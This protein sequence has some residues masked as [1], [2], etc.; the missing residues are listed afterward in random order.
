[1]E[2]VEPPKRIKSLFLSDVHLG[3]IENNAATALDIIEKYHFDNLF[4]VGDIIDIKELRKK[5]RWNSL[6]TN[7]IHRIIKIANKKNVIYITGNHERGF[8]DDLPDSGLPIKFFR[9]LVYNNMLIIHGDQFDVVIG[10]RKWL[11]NVGDIGYNWSIK[12]THWINWGRRRLGLKGECK[13]S[14]N[15]K[16]LVKNSINYLSDYHTAAAEYAKYR[17]CHTVICGHTHQQEFRKVEDVRYF[18]IGNMRQDKQYLIEELDG[19]LLLKDID[20]A[21]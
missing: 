21:D 16:K 5:W 8:F 12:L 14:K 2:Y 13:L 6:D 9:E 19:S 17:K 20:K 15:L 3:A 1:M 18:N 11:Y 4:L 7:I 10:N